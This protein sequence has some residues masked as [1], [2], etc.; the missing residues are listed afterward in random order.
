MLHRRT[1]PSQPLLPLLTTTHFSSAC[2][3]SS[4]HDVEHSVAN[5]YADAIQNAQHFVYIENQFFITA[6]SDEQRPVANKLLKLAHHPTEAR[7]IAGRSDAGRPAAPNTENGVA[8]V[9][10]RSAKARPSPGPRPLWAQPH[11]PA[12]RVAWAHTRN[13]I[14]NRSP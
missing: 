7:I 11:P 9:V 4:G 1:H 12:S 2:P 3:W 6:T 8:V 13:A 14:R 10:G 5:A